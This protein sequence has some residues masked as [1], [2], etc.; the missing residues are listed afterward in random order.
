MLS[1]VEHMGSGPSG[2]GQAHHLGLATR[3]PNNTTPKPSG[4]GGSSETVSFDN[5]YPAIVQCFAIIFAGYMAGRTNMINNSQARGIGTFVSKFCLPSL[6]LK[7]MC[8][9]KFNEVNWRFL[10]S[11]LI[12]KTV[13]F[14]IIV[15]FTLLIKRPVNL[16]YAGLFA[17]FSTQSN[18]FA[19]G[20]PI[21]KLSD[22][23]MSY[24]HDHIESQ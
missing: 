3:L 15:F 21:G 1:F 2:G 5:L 20:Y 17:I 14:F 23:G 12:A 6:L 10:A 22:Q 16:G 8:E 11:I 13:I 9:L 7:S 18:D 19:F 4:G 24:I